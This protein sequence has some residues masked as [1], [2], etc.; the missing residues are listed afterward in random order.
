M[1]CARPPAISATVTGF[2]S[3]EPPAAAIA[4]ST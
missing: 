1:V 3:K 4:R 2:T